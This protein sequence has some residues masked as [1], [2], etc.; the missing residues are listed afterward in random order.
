[1]HGT[2]PN[3]ETQGKNETP[4]LSTENCL[5]FFRCKTKILRLV[6]RSILS[7]SPAVVHSFLWSNKPCLC[8]GMSSVPS[9]SAGLWEK[10]FQFWL[11]KNFRVLVL[12]HFKHHFRP[13]L[14]SESVT[15]SHIKLIKLLG[16]IQGAWIAVHRSTMSVDRLMQAVQISRGLLGKK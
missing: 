10:P 13:Q 8:Y 7:A 14:S 2:R 5:K 3:D 6:S 4:A 11:L 12:G 9:V 16:N 15:H 1:M